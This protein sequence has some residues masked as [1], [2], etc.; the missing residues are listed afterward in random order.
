MPRRLAVLA[1]LLLLPIVGG[2][3]PVV[4]VVVPDSVDLPVPAFRQQADQWCWLAVAEMIV[5]YKKWGASPSQC[6]LLEIGT[7][8]PKGACCADPKRCDRPGL[9]S[10]IRRV[11]EHFGGAAS[12][13]TP[14]LSPRALYGALRDGH[15]VVAALADPAGRSGHV[16]VIKGMSF[17]VRWHPPRNA[18]E[19]PGQ[20][21]VPWVSINDPRGIITESVPYEALARNWAASIVVE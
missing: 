17:R 4:P 12:A 6:E 5:F 21:I 13:Q 2:G 9:L 15:V 18:D 7:G 1:A 3:E 20:E 16:V 19:P 8:A 10:E 14:P 11:I